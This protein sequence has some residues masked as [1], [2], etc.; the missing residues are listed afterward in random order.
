ML[1]FRV[2]NSEHNSILLVLKSWEN[3]LGVGGR[4]GTARMCDVPNLGPHHMLG[5]Q[6][7]QK[8]GQVPI[9]HPKAKPVNDKS[10][11]PDRAPH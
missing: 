3:P 7:P 1:I 9:V 4:I 2:N 8:P 6:G 5:S 10:M 11:S